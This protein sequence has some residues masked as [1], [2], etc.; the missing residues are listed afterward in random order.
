MTGSDDV[1]AAVAA[2]EAVWE[3]D[4]DRFLTGVAPAVEREAS[5]VS[6]LMEER[7]SRSGRSGDLQPRRKTESV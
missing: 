3:S 6:D 7:I 2:A 1:S 5:E 4:S